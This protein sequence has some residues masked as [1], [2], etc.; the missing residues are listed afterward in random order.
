VALLVN[1]C[2]DSTSKWL[3]DIPGLVSAS[4]STSQRIPPLVH[5]PPPLASAVLY[6]QQDFAGAL[7]RSAQHSTAKSFV[8]TPATHS[9][10]AGQHYLEQ[11]V[12]IAQERVITPARSHCSCDSVRGTSTTT[13]FAA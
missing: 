12:D 8:T 4:G 10:S 9:I 5:I 13:Q 3:T 2:T 11:A 7:Q 1:M 6:S